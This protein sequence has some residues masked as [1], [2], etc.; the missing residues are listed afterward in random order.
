MTTRRSASDIYPPQNFVGLPSN[1]QK[2][3]AYV[4]QKTKF[5]RPLLILK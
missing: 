1:Q 2:C 4:M 5:D 3:D